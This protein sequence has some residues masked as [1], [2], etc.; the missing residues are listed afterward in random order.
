[1]DPDAVLAQIRALIGAMA[2]ADCT[3]DHRTLLAA[4]LATVWDGLDTWLGR[5]G[6]LPRAWVL[7]DPPPISDA[8]HADDVRT[9]VRAIGPKPF[10]EREW[11]GREPLP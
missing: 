1:M 7:A 4:D 8:E 9:V 11:L 5:G 10:D 6:F 3:A 2:S